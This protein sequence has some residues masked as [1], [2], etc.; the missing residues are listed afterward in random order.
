[1]IRTLIAIL[2]AAA[3]LGVFAQA[4][5]AGEI[6]VNVSGV[7]GGTGQVGCALHA[8]EDTFPMG[9]NGV[10]M[11]WVRPKGERATCVFKNVAAGTYAVAVSHD[12]NGNRK[13][14]TNLF[15]LPKEAWGVSGNIRPALRAPR[16]SEAVFVVARRPVELAVVVDK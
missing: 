12:L 14:D 5:K 2:L 4:P 13:T 8:S 11:V 1:M 15:G 7:S 9:H 16:F 10:H 6:R 3:G